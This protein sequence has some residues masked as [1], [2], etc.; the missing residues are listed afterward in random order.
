MLKYGSLTPP[1]YK[2]EKATAPMYIYYGN[3]D[4]LVAPQ[5]SIRRG[6]R[7]VYLSLSSP[8]EFLNNY[9]NWVAIETLY[10]KGKVAHKPGAST[11]IRTPEP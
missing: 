10:I 5:V 11:G 2:V 9:L 1:A 8:V 7:F 3:N 4:W 6:S